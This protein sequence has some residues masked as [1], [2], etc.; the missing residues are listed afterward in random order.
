MSIRV[1]ALLLL[2]ATPL[3]G[4]SGSA[5]EVLASAVRA[6][7]DLEFDAAARMLRHV[8]TPPLA[9]GLD[10]SARTRALTYLGAAEHY[11]G[12]QD[13]A[14][15]VFQRLAVL[16]PSQR[17]DTLIFPP[18]ITRLYDAVRTTLPVPPPIAVTAPDT[19]PRL[20]P[21]AQPPPPP[22]PAVLEVPPAAPALPV[23][24]SQG[25]ELKVTASGAGQ[26]LSVRGVTALGFFGSVRFHRLE[27]DVRYAE[28]QR[29]ALVE[30]A[31]A[32]RFLA[33]PWLSVQMGPHARRFDTPFGA[34]RWVTWR[35]GGRGELGLAGTGVRG[36]ALLWRALA[37]D[38][39]V[40][41]GAG[42][43]RGGEVGV[44]IDLESR[45]FWF[46]LAYG[47]D[48]AHVRAAAR[49]ETV[50]TVTLMVGLRRR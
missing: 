8:L 12:R 9:I 23:G 29:R 31:V 39:N 20:Q 6:Y 41:P 48:Q 32:L 21:P 46:G 3:R 45:P 5:S 42:S 44:T 11:R 33:T 18:E 47:I 16:A 10:D 40:P 19:L 30:G 28:G 36:H 22:P 25:N 43:A 7:R 38:V 24:A 49:R 17:P 1:V 2:L 50:K 26:V 34:E 14:I 37:L 13:S 4:Q 15:A 27:L 35:L